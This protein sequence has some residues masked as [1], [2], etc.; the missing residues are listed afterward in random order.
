MSVPSDRVSNRPFSPPDLAPGHRGDSL[1][2]SW[3][4]T[5]PYPLRSLA[6]DLDEAPDEK[7]KKD[8]RAEKQPAI[9]FYLIAATAFVTAGVGAL[10]DQFWAAWVVDELMLGAGYVSCFVG[11]CKR[12]ARA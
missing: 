4:P 11:C 1:K 8:R 6:D 3:M 7:G 10:A 5:I 2:S 9:M 12:A